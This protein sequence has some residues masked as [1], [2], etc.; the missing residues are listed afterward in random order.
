[1]VSERG[2]EVDP[3][4]IRA[5]LNMSMPRTKRE[6]KGFLGRLQYIN[7]FITRLI[8][9]CEPIFQLLRKSQPTIWDDQC[10]RAFEMIREYLLSPPVL[11]PPTPGRPLLLYLSVSDVALGC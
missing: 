6:I 11:A 3:D 10:Q 8:D 5:I 7:R 2:I 9:I 1:M 4:K